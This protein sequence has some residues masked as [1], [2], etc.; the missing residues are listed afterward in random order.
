MKF[1]KICRIL[2]LLFFAG[3]LPL[4]GGNV[5]ELIPFGD[6][7]SWVTRVIKESAVIGGKEKTVYEIA[8]EAVVSGNKPYSNMG[9]S[10]WATSNVY[11]K[12]AGINKGSN[13]VFPAA[14]AGHG[15]CARL[16]TMMESVRVLHAVNMDVLVAGSIFLGEMIEPITNTKNPMQKMEMG[17]PY[18]KRPACVTFDYMLEVPPGDFRIKSSGFGSKKTLKGR[19]AAVVFVLLQERWEDENGNIHARRIGTGGRMFGDPTGWVEGYRLPIVYGD[20]SGQPG[21]E[22]LGLRRGEQRYYARN[23]RGKMVPVNED[24]WG[25]GS[26]TPTHVILMIS[27]AKG[28]PYV[29]TPG[30]TLYVD[31]V[32]FGF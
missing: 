6:F 4:S 32:G 18:G 9:G 20:C 7:N 26:E 16:C 25:A 8:P 3:G 22:W 27:S 19:D 1:R 10:P 14:H 23:S 11:A 17:M 29:G 2:P 5:V 30:M 12:V 24:E 31:N 21:M 28:E 15:Q 13:A